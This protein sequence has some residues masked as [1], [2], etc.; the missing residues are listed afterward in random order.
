MRTFSLRAGSNYPVVARAVADSIFAFLVGFAF[1]GLAEQA[2]AWG[3]TG[4]QVICEIAFQEL[5][6]VAR[7]QVKALIQQD[8]GYRTFAESC[9]WPDKIRGQERYRHYK[10]LHFVNAE[11]GAASMP[12]ACAE[13]CILSAIPDEAEVL[14]DTDRTVA[15]RIE[16]LKFLGHFVGDLHQPLH[17]GYSHDFGGNTVTV[18]Y[19]GESYRLHK[20]WDTLLIGQRTNA[21]RD[22]AQQ[23]SADV[24]PVDRTVWENSSP[25]IWANESFQ[26]VERTVYDFADGEDLARAYYRENIRTAEERLTAA[27]VRLARLLNRVF[28]PVGEPLFE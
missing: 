15:R 25:L 13:G 16:A 17:A 8:S 6:S 3:N 11:R 19:Y 28:G 21:W 20:V 5:S 2:F 22:L 18:R 23:L 7:D 12:E 24:T 10:K 14:R 1:L 26:I 27:G 9:T 4:H